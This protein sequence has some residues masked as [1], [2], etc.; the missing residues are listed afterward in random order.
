M[1]LIKYLWFG[2]KKA[3]LWLRMLWSEFYVQSGILL[4]IFM[5]YLL[6]SAS[7]ESLLVKKFELIS[8]LK[9]ILEQVAFS[10]LLGGI[11]TIMIGLF[12]YK[13]QKR[14]LN[15]DIRN[16]LVCELNEICR[17]LQRN[18][19]VLNAIDTDSN[20]KISVMHI[21]KLE[22]VINK[23]FTDEELLKNM[24]KRY[25][26]IV[27]PL[28]VRMRNYNITVNYLKSALEENKKELFEFYLTEII[29]G[30]IN[31]HKRIADDSVNILVNKID[32]IVDQCN[33]YKKNIYDGEWL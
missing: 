31:L 22:I 7:T 23:T 9:I 15:W 8:P 32:K 14:V 29:S 21:Q 30:T 33:L 5:L 11:L 13:A 2:I 25:T 1:K 24:N 27:F 20:K 10:K 6:K 16:R 17:H 12:V 28:N 19:E 3:W 26:A 18:L 4:I